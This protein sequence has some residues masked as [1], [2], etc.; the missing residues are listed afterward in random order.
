MTVISSTDT[1]TTSTP[2]S[3]SDKQRLDALL[4][5]LARRIIGRAAGTNIPSGTRLVEAPQS[6]LWLGML[7]SE[8]KLIA[9]ALTGDTYGERLVPPAQG[10]TFRLPSLPAQLTF[11]VTAA[12]YL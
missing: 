9:E 8:P 2:A 3:G 10:F 7:E 6:R 4:G 11:T 5:T 1:P 12:T